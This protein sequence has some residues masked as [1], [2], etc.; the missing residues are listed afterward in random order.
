MWILFDNSK[1]ESPFLRFAEPNVPLVAVRPSAVRE[2]GHIQLVI[3]PL[4]Q[5]KVKSQSSLLPS[6]GEVIVD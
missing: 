3:V 2:A 1:G 5:A 4:R 6:G